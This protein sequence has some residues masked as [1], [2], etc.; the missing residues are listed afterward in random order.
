M[1]VI[2]F[3]GNNSQVAQSMRYDLMHGAPSLYDKYVT[4]S[5]AKQNS[6][7]A[8]RN[9]YNHNDALILGIPCKTVIVPCALKKLNNVAYLR[10]IN[11]TLVI[12]SASCHF[13]TTCAIFEDVETNKR[14]IIKETHCNTY[15]CELYESEV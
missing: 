4:P 8:I 14:Y 2:H 5:R 1:K 9:D 13:Y 7:D 11:G 15:M 10:Y 12:A 3:Y 6:F